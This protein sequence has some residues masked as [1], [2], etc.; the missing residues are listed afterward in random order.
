MDTSVFIRSIVVL[1]LVLLSAFFSSAETAM[2]TVSRIRV[3]SLAEQGDKRA[4]LLERI[5]ADS[6]KMLSTILIGNNIVNMAVSAL[7]TT[8]TIDVLG[9]RFVGAATGLLTLVILLFGEITPKSMAAVHAERFALSYARSIYVLLI[10]LTPVV[11]V[12]G[13]LSGG[14]IRLF[15]VDP[16][17]KSSPLTE[18]ELRTL[19]NESQKDGVIEREEKQMIYNVFDFGDSTAK[20]VMIPRVDMTFVEVNCTRQELLDIFRED[21]HTRFPVY[22]EDTDNVIGTI[23]I[24]DLILLPEEEG[25]SIRSILREPYFTYEY[26]ATADL[27]IEM[28]KASVNL[29]IVLDEYGTT[30]G[31]VTL[32]DLLEEIV[33]EIRDEYD[34]DEK[35]DLT[36]IQP[37]REYAASGSARLEDI[38]EALGTALSSGEYDS[39][40]GFIIEQLDSLP[41]EGQSLTLPDGVRLVVDSIS[42]NRI[43]QVHIWMPEKDKDLDP[44]ENESR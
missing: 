19:V 16:N 5:I 35:E 23:N 12:V 11:F 43:R 4:A 39:I 1:L 18:H 3:Q 8:L 34:E 6:G 17:A 44:S 36:A 2:T 29:A 13:K 28:R 10:L 37:G 31:L 26:K 21:R 22:E 25:F 24:K 27:M 38:N 7:V 33:G 14:I 15:G 40:G 32:E 20:D 9:S 30:A 42:Q 41:V